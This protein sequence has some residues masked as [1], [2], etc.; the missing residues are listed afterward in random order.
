MGP[1]AS[2]MPCGP[3][4]AHAMFRA[5]VAGHGGTP[6]LLANRQRSRNS[7]RFGMVSTHTRFD[8]ERVMGLVTLAGEVDPAWPPAVAQHPIDAS[9][10]NAAPL[11]PRTHTYPLT[12]G[13]F[14]TFDPLSSTPK[15]LDPYELATMLSALMSAHTRMDVS[16]SMF[17]ASAAMLVRGSHRYGSDRELDE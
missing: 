3:V 13:G 10:P 4:N 5:V 12:A 14:G 15:A 7:P 2:G 9:L 1:L 11:Y 17:P 16:Q 8:A 6:A